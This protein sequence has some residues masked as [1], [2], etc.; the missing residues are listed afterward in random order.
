MRGKGTKFIVISFK[1]TLRLPGKRELEVKFRIVLVRMI[2][3]SA[4]DQN[5]SKLV[6]ILAWATR[7][8]ISFQTCFLSVSDLSSF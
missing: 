7:A 1:S 8:F 3:I 5:V 2:P 6:K 4:T